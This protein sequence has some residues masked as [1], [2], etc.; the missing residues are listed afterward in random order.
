MRGKWLLSISADSW[1]NYDQGFQDSSRHLLSVTTNLVDVAW[2]S[3]RP[4]VPSQPIYA[5]PKEFT[6]DSIGL[7]SF[8]ICTNKGP[9][10]HNPQCCWWYFS[11]TISRQQSNVLQTTWDAWLKCRFFFF[12]SPSL[13]TESKGAQTIFRKYWKKKSTV[14]IWRKIQ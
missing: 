6:G 2:G 8:W 5:L 10:Q 12:V 11:L 1:K 7:F 9:Y 4:P 13:L 3:E 14:R